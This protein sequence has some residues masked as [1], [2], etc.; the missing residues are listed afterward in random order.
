MAAPVPYQLAA[1]GVVRLSDNLLITPD[2]TEWQAYRAWLKD[3]NAPAPL[4]SPESATLAEVLTEIK[5]MITARRD[6]VQAGGATVNGM[7]VK[8]DSSSLALLAQA[9][10]FSA[11]QPARLFEVKT[12]D[13]QHI[14]MGAAQ[15][16]GLFDLLGE[17]VAACWDNEAAHYAL[18]ADIANGVD[19]DADKIT[20]LRAYD[21]STGWP[22]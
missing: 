6:A 1:V 17:R 22:A 15:I 14:T 11:L 4:P 9:V 8:T 21:F 16:S 3:G 12:A 2:K 7:T 5:I 13:M 19:P 20:A 18:V 10:Q